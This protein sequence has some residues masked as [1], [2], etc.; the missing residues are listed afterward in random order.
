[1]HQRDSG[2]RAIE[3]THQVAVDLRLPVRRSTVGEGAIDADPGVVEEQVDAAKTLTYLIEKA[4][5]LL[6]VGAVAAPMPL[7]APVITATRPCRR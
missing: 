4:S 7:E 6:K 5:Y 3:D 2:V 1:L